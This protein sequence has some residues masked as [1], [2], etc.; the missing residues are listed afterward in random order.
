MESLLRIIL[1][2]NSE[3][4]RQFK[5]LASKQCAI[6]KKL[7]CLCFLNI[8]Y[9]RHY[10]FFLHSVHTRKCAYL[11]LKLS[12][13]VTLPSV[14]KPTTIAVT[15]YPSGIPARKHGNGQ[16]VQAHFLLVQ[17]LPGILDYQIRTALFFPATFQAHLCEYDRRQLP[18]K[19]NPQ[20]CMSPH[21]SSE[22]DFPA[23]NLMISS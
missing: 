22:S 13:H 20:S 15:L 6:S 5:K 9:L 17:F 21:S 23:R 11:T 10:T 14:L 19:I 3:R 1:H 8:V 16:S 7:I 2:S 12:L 18:K 4:H